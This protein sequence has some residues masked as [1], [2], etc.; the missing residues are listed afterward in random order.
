MIT[1][2]M[3]TFFS[4]RGSN[5]RSWYFMIFPCSFFSHLLSP[6]IAV[7]MTQTLFRPPRRN[8]ISRVLSVRCWTIC[9]QKSQRVFVSSFSMILS[10]LCSRFL[11]MVNCTSCKDS[12][13]SCLQ[14]YVRWVIL[15]HVVDSIILCLAKLTLL[16]LLIFWILDFILSILGTCSFAARIHF[17]IEVPVLEALFSLSFKYCPCKCSCFQLSK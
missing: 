12:S 3:V 14:F 15:L 13:A 4:Q 1:D 16:F 7:S 17:F 11:L 8:G 6:R 9:N 10:V 2:M 5:S